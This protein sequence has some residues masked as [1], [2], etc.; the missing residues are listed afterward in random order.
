M[1][2]LSTRSREA[3]CLHLSYRLN[4]DS[5]GTM[6]LLL[7]RCYRSTGLGGN[8]HPHAFLPNTLS[9]MGGVAVWQSPSQAR[10]YKK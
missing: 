1:P 7:M 8:E 5:E 3:L 6:T 9:L 2:D 4:P 10:F